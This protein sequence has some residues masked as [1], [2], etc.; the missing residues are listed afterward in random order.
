[1]PAMNDGPHESAKANSL[2]WPFPSER[3]IGWFL[4]LVSLAVYVAS[5]SW[6]PFPGLPTQTLLVHLGRD[7]APGTLDLLWGRVIR[8]L[9]RLPGLSVAGWAGLFSA[10]CGAASVGLAGRL[11]MRVGYLVDD[12]LGGTSCDREAQA[13]LLSGLVSGM[14]MAGSIP[15]WMVS[16]RS[17]PGAFHLLLLL[18]TGW[19]FSEYQHGGKQRYL[20]LLGLFYGIGLT[21]FVAFLVCLPLAVFL[22]SRE[23]FRWQALRAWRPQLVLWGGLCL[24][25]ALYP[26]NAFM[27][28]RPGAE[29]GPFSSFWQAWGRILQDQAQR[30]LLFPSHNPPGFLYILIFALVTWLMLFAMSHRSPWFYESG[31]MLVRLLLVAGGLGVLYN[32]GL[33]PWRMP[34]M[35]NLVVTA[36]VVLATCTGY[37]AGE[38][39]ILGEPQ[40]LVDSTFARR[41]ARRARRLSSAFALSLPA[42]VVA[43]GV[44]NWRVVDGRYG[45]IM[46]ATAREVLDRLDGRDILFSAGP[47]DDL[48]RMEVW[49]RK[50]PIHLI[51]IPRT[52]SP[53]YLQ[54]LAAGFGEDRLRRP[55]LQQDFNTFA[56]NLLLSDAGPS[57]TAFIDLPDVFRPFGYLVPDGFL[58]RLETTA[59]QVSWKSLLERQQPV[60]ER[61]A[62]MA[63]HPVPEANLIRPYQDQLRLMASK[64]ANN[65]GVLQ[66]ERGDEAEALAAFRAARRI[67]PENRSVLLNLLEMNRSHPL[68]EAAELAAEWK[69]QQANPGGWRW[70]LAIQ[71][72][73]VWRAREWVRRGWVWA[74]SGAPAAAEGARRHLSASD[75]EADQRVQLLDQAYL[76][77]GIPSHAEDYYCSVLMQD[78]KNPAALMELCRLALGRNDPEAAEAYLAEAIAMGLPKE[79]VLFDRAMIA[80]VRGERGQALALLGT[81]IRLTPG[82]ARVWMALALLS[83]EQDPL[84]AMAMKTLKDLR[85]LGIGGR[86]ALA[87]VY[88]SRRLWTEAQAELEQ[89]LQMDSS[90]MQAWE[91]LVDLAHECGNPNLMK[92]GLSVLLERNPEHFLHYQNKG[93]EQ[94]QQGELAEAEATFRKGL[95]R[96]R[97]PVLLNNLASVI[98]EQDGDIQEALDLANEALRRQP[99]QA[100]FLGTRGEIYLKMGRFEEAR[101]DLQEAL[102]KRGRNNGLLL[103]L[104]R[105]YEGVGDRPRALAV[106]TALAKQAGLLDAKQRQQLN[107]LQ[108]RLR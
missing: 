2:L 61:M 70:A 16:T 33:A 54:Q 86:L 58:Y 37:M 8:L 65:L 95:Q 45:R 56:G 83:D 98:L 85:T 67:Y 68:P 15:V 49:A 10:L 34:D 59:D 57:R 69:T 21:E 100:V 88:M 97:A 101:M 42:I 23:M 63:R 103:M 77:W 82:D 41:F 108:N 99:G 22:V 29:M 18:A 76:R 9:A 46:E 19:F 43:G 1:M 102:K 105:S 26:F 40:P 28:F 96:K 24:G 51:S 6:A 38:F 93:V 12:E 52:S 91:M 25:L 50:A 78:E 75:V 80:D 73:Y 32:I 44:H 106:V 64:V 27:L 39:W 30:I 104:A 14:F 79:G 74:L 60:W 84:N 90:N 94:Y 47:L 31:Q 72:G 7:V 48:L 81:L 36:Y 35:S 20:S 5:M 87:S 4:F 92:T 107:S 55:L 62:Q 53:Q 17:L 3:Q 11:M 71:Y 89:A 13:R 66:A